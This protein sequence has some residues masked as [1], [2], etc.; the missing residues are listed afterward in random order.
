M[1]CERCHIRKHGVIQTTPPAT[2]RI[3][4]RVISD[5]VAIDRGHEMGRNHARTADTRLL[6]APCEGIVWSAILDAVNVAFHSGD[7]GQ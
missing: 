1:N 5:H 2:R 7:G 3:T 6:C 4:V